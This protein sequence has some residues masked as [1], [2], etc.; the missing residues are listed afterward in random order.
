MAMAKINNKKM[1]IFVLIL[2][3]I[4]R[5]YNLLLLPIFTDESIYLYWAK[6]IS[7]TNSSWFISLGDGKPPLLIWIIALLLKILPGNLYLLAGRLPSVLFGLMTLFGIYKFSKLLFENARISFLSAVLYIISPFALL[8]DRMALFDSM[9][10]S[11]LLWASY[12]AVKT[13]KTLDY[14]DAIMWGLFIGTAFLSKGTAMI[15]YLLLPFC[16]LAFLNY[17][18]VRINFKKIIRL[19]VISSILGFGIS[20]ILRLSDGYILMQLKNQQFQ[21]PWSL[22]LEDPFRQLTGNYKGI[23]SW[24]TSYLTPS[25]YFFGLLSYFL[26]LLKKNYKNFAV[27]FGLWFFPILVFSF[28][29]RELFPRYL[30]FILPYF[31]IAAAYGFS[32]VYVYITSKIIKI[33]VTLV[34]LTILIPQVFF[35]YYIITD[36]QKAPLPNTDYNQ[37]VGDHPSGFGLETIFSKLDEL[38]AKNKITLVTQGTFGLYPYAFYLKYWGNPNI[39]IV[40]KWPIDLLKLDFPEIEKGTKFYLIMKDY[41]Q[42]P[43]DFPLKVLAIGEKPGGRYPIIL[44]EVENKTNNK[45]GVILEGT[46]PSLTWRSD[47]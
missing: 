7:E 46:K 24:L 11:M 37:Y 23:M 39:R 22:I 18:V 21:Q 10:L 19:L 40:P 34:L 15:V 38:S 35:S 17:K 6:V 5:F 41:E 26:M 44:A 27:L 47:R 9:L 4:S 36:P 20:S 2:Y 14:K 12:F 31:L 29:A 16:F 32:T 25:F 43:K 33:P 1:L 13:A 8:Y 45:K 3:L 28:F 42:Y 30:L